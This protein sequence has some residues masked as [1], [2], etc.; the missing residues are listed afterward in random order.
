MKSHNQKPLD[1]ITE[2][3]AK[4]EWSALDFL[5]FCKQAIALVKEYPEDKDKLAYWIVSHG[6]YFGSIDIVTTDSA[7]DKD[8]QIIRNLAADLELPDH[9]VYTDDGLSVKEKWQFMEDIVEG[10]LFDLGHPS[11]DGPYSAAAEKN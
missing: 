1:F 2:F 3:K 7:I 5:V 8:I 11:K 6:S 9:H 10:A 4:K